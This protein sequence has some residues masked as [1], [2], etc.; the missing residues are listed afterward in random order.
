MGD[1]TDPENVF[2]WSIVIMNL[3]GQHNYDLSKPRVWKLNSLTGEMAAAT[4]VYVDDLHTLGASW[5]E[6][7]KVMH[8]IA[9]PLTFLPRRPPTP[10]HGPWAGAVSW[11]S[12]QGIC[13]QSTKEK[14]EKAQG[15]VRQLQGGPSH[16]SVGGSS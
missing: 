14:W 9:I 16:L 12:E 2:H 4:L 5:E 10:T 11:A 8:R 15:S 3:L 6:C 7:W 13:I 1:K